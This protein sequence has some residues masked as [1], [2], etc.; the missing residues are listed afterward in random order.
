V[1]GQTG[2]LDL[3]F[4]GTGN[5]ISHEGRAHS[6]FL[7]NGRYL[8]DAGPT[9]LQQM[10]KSRVNP[11]DVRV[12]LVSHFHA[13]HYFGLPFLLL[14]YWISE[15]EDELHI[16]G[17]PGIEER[18]ETL[19]ELAFPGLPVRNKGYR[20]RYFEIDD[21]KN[22]DVEG[23]EFTGIEVE[24]VP[25]LRCFGYRATIAGRTLAYSG[26]AVMCNGLLRLVTDAEVLVLDC[27][28][29]GDSVHL[30]ASDLSEVMAS[31]PPRATAIVSHLG[32]ST[33]AVEVNALVA[34]DLARFHF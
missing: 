13:D 26:D 31:A 19:L 22:G 28:D 16:V 12:V 15:R 5:A 27:S 20:R 33:A 29:G 34:S 21:G 10:K 2:T 4:L 6:S 25:S 17:P 18:T 11:G 32:S 8:F 24:H 30:A 7:V 9:T 14:D 1:A 23:L 3:L